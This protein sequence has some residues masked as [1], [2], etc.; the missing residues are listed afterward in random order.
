MGK[1]QSRSK[2]H[3]VTSI[4]VLFAAMAVGVVVVF[5]Q[6][7]LFGFV[8]L[9][10][11]VL[12]PLPVAWFFCAK[13]PCRLDCGHVIMGAITRM[14]PAR[15]PEPYVWRD[16]V[17]SA[18]LPLAAFAFPQ[19]WLWQEKPAFAVFWFFVAMGVTQ[20]R[21][22]VCPACSNTYCP[23]N[24]AQMPPHRSTPVASP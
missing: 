20:A 2:L 11:A 1:R 8:D 16:G 10:L 13:C 9:A 7:V 4:V 23:M 17:G 22:G 24:K 19:Y 5:R 15:R 18:L 14:Y 21:L 12:W 6:S 3:G